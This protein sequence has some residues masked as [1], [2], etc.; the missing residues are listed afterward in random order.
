[1][2]DLVAYRMIFEKCTSEKDTKNIFMPHT[3]IH[4]IINGY[5]YVN[6]VKLSKGD[7]FSVTKNSKIKYGP[8]SE[9]PWEY[10][11]A[12]F[13]GE[14]V[15]T[16][17]VK[18]GLNADV[19]Y[20]KMNFFDQIEAIYNLYNSYCEMDTDNKMFKNSAGNM[21][22]SLFL[23]DKWDKN[24]MLNLRATD[25]KEF[26]DKNYYLKIT[27]EDVAKKMFLS[28]AYMRNIFVDEYGMAPKKYLQ[29]IRMER[30]AELI[31]KEEGKISEIARSV[32]YEDQLLFSKM[33]KSYFGVSP[34]GYNKGD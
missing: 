31:M 18:V 26:I 13:E 3:S 28:R 20:G 6:D 17:M 19:T 11:Y 14:D 12:D 27:M 1:M 32:G 29:K 7:F 2:N 8:D 21:I 5:G 25:I 9:E 4:F 16:E 15:V 10:I 34:K 33:F 30:A 23:R 22:L 24:S